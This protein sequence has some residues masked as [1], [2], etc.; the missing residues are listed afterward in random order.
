MVGQPGLPGAI[1]ENL[2][3]DVIEVGI[4]DADDRP[5]IGKEALAVIHTAVG[6]HSG[7]VSECWLHIK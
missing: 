6:G 7:E 5:D 1:M 3:A 2:S 4:I